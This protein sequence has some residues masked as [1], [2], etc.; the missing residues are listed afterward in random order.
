MRFRT[1][2]LIL[3]V[4]SIVPAAAQ[5]YPAPPAKYHVDL[6]YKIAAEQNQ[7][8]RDYKA[9]M[10]ALAKLGFEADPREDADLDQ[11]D[12][13]AE[14]LAGT[15][16]AA[17][18]K[19]LL[20]IAAIRTSLLRDS[21]TPLPDNAKAPVQLRIRIASGLGL[22]EQRTLHEQVVAQ[23]GRIG[24]TEQ[25]AYAHA[26]YSLVRGA[27]PAGRVPDLLR[28]LRDQPSGWFFS[29]IPRDQLNLPL[30]DIMPVRQVEVLKD[31]D[32]GTAVAP[33]AALPPAI[34]STKYSLDL[35]AY[36]AEPGAAAKSLRVELIM[37]EPLPEGARVFRELLRLRVPK[38][39]ME[40]VFGNFVVLRLPNAGDLVKIAEIPAVRT[41]RL[42]RMA[43]AQPGGTEGDLAAALRSGNVAALHAAGYRGAGARVVVLATEFAGPLPAG[44][45]L[46]DLTAELSPTIEPAPAGLASRG[47]ETARAVKAA[48]PDA[49]LVLVRIDPIAVHQLI[50][51]AKAVLGDATTSVALVSRGDELIAESERLNIRRELVQDEYRKAFADLSDDEKPAKRRLDA[52]AAFKA[53][54]ADEKVFKAKYDRLTK[55]RTDL[56]ELKGAQVIVNMLVWEDGYAHDGLSETSQ[57]LEARLTPIPTRSGLRERKLPTVPVWVQAG[58]TSAGSVWAGAFVDGDGN[59]AM[60]FGPKPANGWTGELNFLTTLGADGKPVDRL[61][62]GAKIRLSI[63][64]REPRDP[65]TELSGLASFPMTLKLLR[66]ID[67]TGAAT[68]SDDFAVVASSFGQPTR[69]QRTFTSAVYEQTMEIAIP[70]DGRYALR[71][72]GKLAT[73]TLAATNRQTFELHPRIYATYTGGPVQGRLAFATHAPAASGVAI[74]GDARAAITVGIGGGL[75]GS[76]PGILLGRKPDLLVKGLESPASATGVVAGTVACLTEAGVHANVVL[77]LLVPKAGESLSVP[78]E[79]IQSLPAKTADRR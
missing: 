44:A 49:Q 36:L 56:T 54:E 29:E 19:G 76:G 70:A 13:S 20:D 58:S 39:A 43:S 17:Q 34:A 41:I 4:G 2:L 6:R 12:A 11:F 18:A 52:T 71:V 50:S 27:L 55:L 8:V 33:P 68:A 69:I 73:H 22:A 59:G 3:L 72:E 30:R 60:E 75:N 5:T 25:T 31:V 28:D 9:L 48:A 14:R 79:W 74:P 63:Q 66:Q 10:A 16:P 64:W 67:P 40:G 37:A 23:L 78:N 45:K 57:L 21:A 7:R 51:V 32:F 15:I 61:P 1:S 62:A 77:R 53:L 47:G 42:P 24:F 26:G 46:V 65:D 35:A 38:V